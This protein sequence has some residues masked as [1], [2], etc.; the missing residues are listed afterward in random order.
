VRGIYVHGIFADDQ[1]RAS[2]LEWIGA[3]S[4]SLAFETMI[5]ATLDALADHLEAHVDCDG[6]LKLAR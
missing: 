2:W 1:Q 6:L 4:S 3:D 5:D